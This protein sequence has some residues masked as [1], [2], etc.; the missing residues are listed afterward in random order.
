MTVLTA[1]SQLWKM[2]ADNNWIYAIIWKWNLYCW[3]IMYT[4]GTRIKKMGKFVSSDPRIKI[5]PEAWGLVA[6]YIVVLHILSLSTKYAGTRGTYCRPKACIDA[7]MNFLPWIYCRR[8]QYVQK[9]ATYIVAINC[10]HFK[11]IFK[12]IILITC[13][14]KILKFH[15][16][17]HPYVDGPSW[18][19]YTR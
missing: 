16:C 6:T 10:K 9:S 11:M 12:I 3:W 8:R 2:L 17:V 19:D 7:G 14:F 15:V 5:L 13:K 1:E 4:K 18:Y